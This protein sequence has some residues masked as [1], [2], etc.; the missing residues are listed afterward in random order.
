MQ[1]QTLSLDQLIEAAAARDCRVTRAQVKRVRRA[2]MLQCI[3]QQHRPG[4]RGSRSLYPAS[5]VDQLVL[6]MRLGELER[7]FDQRRVLVAWDDGWVQPQMLKRSLVVILANVS[8]QIRRRMEGVDDPHDAADILLQSEYRKGARSE[9]RRLI[10]QRLD[11]SARG[12]RSVMYVIAALGLGGEVALH[13]HDPNSVEEPLASIIARAL[14]IDK[15]QSDLLG[16]HGPLLPDSVNVEETLHEL[17]DAGMFDLHALEEA[18]TTASEDDV[19]QGFTDAR[20]LMALSSFGEAAEASYGKDVGGIGSLVTALPSAAD[21]EGIATV[22]RGLMIMRRIVPNGA[23]ERM[24]EAALKH[25]LAFVALLELRKEFPEHAEIFTLEMDSKLAE[26][27]PAQAEALRQTV[28]QFLRSRPDLR[29]LLESE[30]AVDSGAE[31]EP[32]LGAG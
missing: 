28:I 21:A 14:G 13:E 5:Q 6:V 30:E 16:S 9:Q 8:A 27:P 1:E 32:E 26:M 18:V 20:L 3:G 19:L 31:A 15:A 22:V 25:R 11:G 17:T 7:R 29:V 4:V 24:A 12:E 23:I 2:G 10:R